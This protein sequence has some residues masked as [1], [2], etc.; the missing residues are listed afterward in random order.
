MK[1]FIAII[2]LLIFSFQVLPVKQLGRLLSKVQNT[3]EVHDWGLDGNAVKDKK[4]DDLKFFSTY[5]QK[6]TLISFEQKV[7]LLLHAAENLPD[8]HVAD[9]LTPPPN[10]C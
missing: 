8:G 3:E 4:A 9:I 7:T 10:C 1:H 2:C 5:S 6:E